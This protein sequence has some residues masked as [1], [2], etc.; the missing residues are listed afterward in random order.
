LLP[1]L[2]RRYTRGEFDVGGNRRLYISRGVGHTLQV[3][4]NVRPE[5]AVFTLTRA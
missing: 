2:N 5:V 3:R 4:F 1:V